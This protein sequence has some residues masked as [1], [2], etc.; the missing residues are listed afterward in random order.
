MAAAVATGSNV[1]LRMRPRDEGSQTSGGTWA[2][3]TPPPPENT[4]CHVQPASGELETLKGTEP[5]CFG[6]SEVSFAPCGVNK[7]CAVW[8]EQN[9]LL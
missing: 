1:Q 7:T 9:L 2:N 3:R 4:G 5:E 8:C 6:V